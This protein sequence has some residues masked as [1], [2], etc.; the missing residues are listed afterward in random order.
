MKKLALY[1]HVWSPPVSDVWKLLVDEQIK[2]IYKS[3]MV[4]YADVYCGINGTT[5]GRVYQFI[6]NYDWI[7]IL[8]VSNTDDQYE[9]FT[10]K[11]LYQHAS[12]GLYDKLGYI[13]TKGLSF[14]SGERDHDPHRPGIRDHTQDKTLIAIN[15]WRHFLEWG[16]I[17][18][19][20]KNID[21]LDTYQ[22]SGV[23]YMASPW[24]H[25]SGNFWWAR[26]DYVKTLE[27]PIT[28]MKK[29]NGWA[30]QRLS[31]ESWVGTGNPNAYSIEN[32]MF[33]AYYPQNDDIYPQV[34][35]SSNFYLNHP[36]Y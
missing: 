18:M 21:I 16:S 2:R 3:G 27:H 26:S 30:D 17:D 34:V 29:R 35:E 15:S 24:P 13:H 36:T 8:D 11:H 33:Q 6:K 20:K 1:Y 32:V 19:W 28:V 10:L 23:N 31:F 4:K 22:T 7:N 14:L 12:D 5:S 25:Y 9:G